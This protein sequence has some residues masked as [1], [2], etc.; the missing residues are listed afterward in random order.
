MATTTMDSHQCQDKH[1]ASDPSLGISWGQGMFFFVSFFMITYSY[2][3][4]G[5]LIHFG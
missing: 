3:F 5:F 1:S 2:H 4:S